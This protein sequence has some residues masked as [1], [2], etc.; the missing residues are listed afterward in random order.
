ME[1]VAK[2]AAIDALTKIGQAFRPGVSS[3]S[4]S[5]DGVSE[6]VSYLTAG[7]YGIFSGAIKSYREWID[8]NLPMLRGSYRGAL[9]VVV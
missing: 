5:R 1:L 3:Q 6:S 4:V 8:Q 7:L 2:K 9:M